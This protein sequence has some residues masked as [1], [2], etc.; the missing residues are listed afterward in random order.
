L[1][2]LE[3]ELVNLVEKVRPSVVAVTV[4]TV[5]EGADFLSKK[6]PSGPHADP[7]R[8]LLGRAQ[9][10]KTRFSGFVVREDG[11]VITLGA[12]M[13]RA[14]K[15]EVAL[16]DGGK[17]QATL[18]GHDPVT[19]IAVVKLDE[20]QVPAAQFGD[21][22]KLRVGCWAIAIGNPYGL[23]HS[24]SYGTVSGLNRSIHAFNR[25]YEGMIQTTCPINPGDTGGVVV[26]T[27]GQVV[28]VVASIYGRAPSLERVRRFY[29]EFRGRS[30]G[31]RNR[32]PER[33]SAGSL[34][35]SEGISFAIPANDV[36]S[37]VEQLIETGQVQRGW[38]GVQ[39]RPAPP[40]TDTKEQVHGVEIV[41]IVPGSPAETGGLQQGDIITT[42]DG[43][44]T[45]DGFRLQATVSRLKPDTAASIGLWRAG[46]EKSLQIKVGLAPSE[47]YAPPPAGPRPGQIPHARP[48]WLGIGMQNLDAELGKFFDVP[49]GGFIL[50][51]EVLENSPARKA[52][53]QVGD[54]ITRA[55]GKPTATT[56]A[57]LQILS[58]KR[59]GDKLP[60]SLLR[61]GK[62]VELVAV[63]TG[64]PAQ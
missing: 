11:Y 35:G 8:K 32:P 58:G 54:V 52:G 9:L 45:P 17:Y 40:K 44:P 7:L 23:S 22:S 49:E 34:I 48:T 27:K 20:R 21:S 46:E 56:Q 62:P 19:G 18:V 3:E 64:P 31:G 10:N 57:L 26:N 24:V 29:H 59:P 51:S 61:K 37:I 14:K 38:L 39:I 50:V 53:L 33:L 55:D 28:G 13:Q 47:L 42:V 1:A 25:R 12:E 2:A 16:H 60:L 4:H 30:F 15:I 63:L 43:K 41:T 5:P 6:L 36:A